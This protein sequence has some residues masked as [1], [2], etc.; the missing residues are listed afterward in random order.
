MSGIGPPA[1]TSGWLWV[2]K[3]E[4][5]RKGQMILKR[6]VDLSLIIASSPLLVLSLIHI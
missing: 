5:R 3:G 2:G 4:R 1:T 6:V